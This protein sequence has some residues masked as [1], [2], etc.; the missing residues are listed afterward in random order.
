VVELIDCTDDNEFTEEEG[1]KVKN[2]T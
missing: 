2:L 1:T